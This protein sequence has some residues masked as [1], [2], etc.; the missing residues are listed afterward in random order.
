MTLAL[1]AIANLLV[2]ACIGL[3]GIAGFLL[4]M[5]YAGFLALAPVEALGLS[6]A[7]F[8]VSGVLGCPA[9][10]RTGDL[11]FHASAWLAAGSL[12]GAVLGVRVGLVLPAHVLTLLLYLVVLC[13]GASV[14]A[15]M[16]PAGAGARKIPATGATTTPDR[17]T[18]RTPQPAPALLALIG[19]ATAV[20]CAAT[21]AGG[22]VLVV[23]ILMLMGFAPRTA[24]GM[25]LIDSVAIAIPSAAGY[26]LSPGIG[27]AVWGL[28]PVALVAHGI[29]VV[30]GSANAHRINADVLKAVVA[31]GSIL[32]ALI[33]LVGML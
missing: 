32:V 19:F 31:V 2:G 28:L 25:G 33:K 18:P 21:G 4:P 27:A 6:F 29:G 16:R 10:R 14:L 23:P 7:A 30:A 17:T 1:T 8:L 3:T 12:A 26:L 13:S 9:Y 20:I 24:V 11:P 5:F 22:P 15:R